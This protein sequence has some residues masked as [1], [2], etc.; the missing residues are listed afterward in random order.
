MF[1]SLKSKAGFTMIEIIGVLAVISV[2]AALVAPKVFDTIADSKASALASDIRTY[3]AA[4]NDW[5]ADIGTLNVLGASGVPVAALAVTTTATSTST[6]D[7]GFQLMNIGIK[8][9]AS[10]VTTGL[11]ARWEGPYLDAIKHTSIGSV[12]Q[13]ISALGTT[14][15]VTA[16][17]NDF[18]FASTGTISSTNNKIVVFITYAAVAETDW[19]RIEDIIDGGKT[20]SGAGAV[21]AR[22]GIRGKV[23]WDGTEGGVSDQG[24]MTIYLASA[25]IN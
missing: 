24:T 9:T 3:T 21:N 20:G 16:T 10:N 17:T 23:K 5:Y 2:L 19:E 22:S 4:V 15:A 14:T 8:G 11:W 1:K 18:A 7:L 6:N 25:L 13:I 12:G